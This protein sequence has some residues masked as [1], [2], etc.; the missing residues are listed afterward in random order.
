MDGFISPTHSDDSLVEN[1]ISQAHDLIALEQIVAISSAPSFT[2]PSHL[3][4]RF[5]RLKSFS[6]PS[7]NLKTPLSHSKI[8][9][10][11]RPNWSDQKTSPPISSSPSK[12]D[13]SHSRRMPNGVN[14]RKEEPNSSPDSRTAS[15]NSRSMNSPAPAKAKAPNRLERERGNGSPSLSSLGDEKLSPSLYS[16]DLSPPQRKGCCFWI[17][18]KK[19]SGKGK[20]LGKYGGFL[21]REDLGKREKEDWGK[22]DE[23]LSDFSTFSLRE[24]RRKLKKAM[25]EQ[26]KINQESEKVVQWVKQASARMNVSIDDDDDLLSDEEKLK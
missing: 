23:L 22:N 26:E 14:Q 8:P 24:Q 1:I 9:K 16:E 13:V 10:K 12:P 3:E 7:P 2:L 15:S 18:P 6:I 20:K 11:H 19:A 4:L 25:K 21:E 5:Q 17:S